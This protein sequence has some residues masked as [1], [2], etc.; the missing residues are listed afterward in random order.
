MPKRLTR[1]TTLALFVNLFLFIIKALAGIISNS[2]AV[3]S[4]AVNSLTDIITS[5]AIKYSVHVSKQEPDKKHQF[6]HGAAQPLAAF[7]VAAF[8][9]VVGIKVIEESVNRIISQEELNI[10]TAIY[11]V[12]IV[13]IIIKLLLNRYKTKIGNLFNSA[14]VRAAAVDS[15]NDVLASSIALL[16]IICAAYGLRFVDGIAGILV[17]F[18]ILKS[19]W[20]VAKENVDYLMGKSA[21]EHTVS[22]I[23]NKVM[24]VKGVRGFNDLRSYYVGDKF[25][26]EIHVEVAKN[27]S[28]KASHDIGTKV[29]K[30]IEELE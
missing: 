27:I 1:I 3:I 24:Q 22:E 14:A 19:G 11:I 5:I 21:D 10:T 13:N 12:L 26:I 6:G 8:A 9:L 25:H 30:C 23:I 16:G 28:T 18:F 20:E 2:I 7:I 29:Q 4:E 15:S 17:A